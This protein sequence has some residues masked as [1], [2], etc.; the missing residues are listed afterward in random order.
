MCRTNRSQKIW[1]WLLLV[2]VTV[3]LQID[4]QIFSSK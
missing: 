1:G 4:N 3:Y 2:K